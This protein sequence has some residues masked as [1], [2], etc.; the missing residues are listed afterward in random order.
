[1]GFFTKFLRLHAT[2]DEHF[3]L[4]VFS[5]LPALLGVKNR[6]ALQRCASSLGVRRAPGFGP[7]GRLGNN[8]QFSG[9]ERRHGWRR[10]PG[11]GKTK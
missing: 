9:H 4:I 11:R 8:S 6:E 3:V 5:I 10:R 7:E 2:S 1:M